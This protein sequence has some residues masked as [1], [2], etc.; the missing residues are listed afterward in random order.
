MRQ[1]HSAAKM[2]TRAVH[3]ALCSGRRAP[4]DASHARSPRRR[5]RATAL[6]DL[7]SQLRRRRRARRCIRRRRRRQVSRARARRRGAAADV[8]V[9]EDAR[10]ALKRVGCGW[11]GRMA[12]RRP[13]GEAVQQREDALGEGVQGERVVVCQRYHL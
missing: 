6:A 10:Q 7:S 4:G 9:G 13:E 5:S 8:P 1:P 3:R 11:M 12:T 2:A